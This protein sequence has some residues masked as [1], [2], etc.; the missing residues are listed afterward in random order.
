M[1]RS[2]RPSL[3]ATGGR[4]ALGSVVTSRVKIAQGCPDPAAPYRSAYWAAPAAHLRAVE[5]VGA[6]ES[7]PKPSS[8]QVT[9]CKRRCY[10]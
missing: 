9:G 6:A 5:V 1:I 4:P 8:G 2:K 3:S 10:N 7:D